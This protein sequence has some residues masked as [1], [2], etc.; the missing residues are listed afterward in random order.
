MVA[1]FFSQRDRADLSSAAA[2]S[3][4][5]GDKT[6]PCCGRS[7]QKADGPE[8]AEAIGSGIAAVRL[9]RRQAWNCPCEGES[10]P[11][12]PPPHDYGVRGHKLELRGLTGDEPKAC[13]WWSFRRPLVQE[14]MKLSQACRTSDGLTPALVLPMDPPARLW[15]GLLHYAR[16]RNLVVTT[17]LLRKGANG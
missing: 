6:L 11:F 4:R 5:L 1:I 2:L 14:V 15:E 8:H 13:P 9:A 3:C 12:V 17:D 10:H 16:V 7:P